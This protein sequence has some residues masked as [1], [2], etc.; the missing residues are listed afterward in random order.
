MY[1]SEYSEVTY[2]EDLNVVLVKWKKFCC[3][4][5]Y[6]KPLLY[7][8]DILINHNNCNYVVDTRDGF[9]NEQA[10]TQWLLNV[11]L[12]QT[13]KTTCKAIFFIIDEDNKLKEH[14]EEQSFELK[15]LFDVYYCFGL[16]EVKSILLEKYN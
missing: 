6:R 5:D 1:L 12:P 9:E 2:L 15:K 8:L 4:D 7:A 16:D 11:F 3:N 10:D 13:T 14:L